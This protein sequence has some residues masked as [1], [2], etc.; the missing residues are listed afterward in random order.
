MRESRTAAVAPVALPPALRAD[1]DRAGYYPELVADTVAAAVGAE[2]VRSHLVHLETT[3]DRDEVRRH[4]TVLA[5]TATRLVV[6]HAD[7][8]GPDEVS[9]APYASASTEAVALSRVGSVVLS[10][11]VSHPDR[12]TAGAPGRE[13]TLAIGWGAVSRVDLEPADCA[14][15]DCEA[16]HGYTGTL[17]PDDISVRVSA[18]AEGEGAVAAALDFARALSAATAGTA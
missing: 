10:H 5:L 12:Y 3:F 15:P 14:D 2:Q 16:D 11:V 6:G 9:S 13:L 7:D 8:H 17:T 4:V 1:I 18:E